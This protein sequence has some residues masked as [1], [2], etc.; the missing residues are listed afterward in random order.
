TAFG[1]GNGLANLMVGSGSGNYLLGGAGNDVL[2]GRGGNDVL[3]GEAGNDVFV[4][5]A[6]TGGDVIGDFTIG[7]DRIDL[8]AFGFAN[9]DQLKVNFSQ[10]GA[11]GAI[12]LGN[13]DFI[14]LHGVTMASLTAA[15]FIFPGQASPAE[16]LSG[17]IPA[18]DARFNPPVQVA[19]AAQDAVKPGLEA[20]AGP[21][22]L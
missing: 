20:D 9:F 19:T 14:V 8:R 21:Q 11:D 17:I 5:Q 12:N 3:F 1:V 4:F 6:G 16:A 18:D 10:V 13:G 15:Q 2:D 7:Q 22:I